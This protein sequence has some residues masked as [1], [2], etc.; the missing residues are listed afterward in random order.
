MGT[1]KGWLF[2]LHR[3]EPLLTLNLFS[4]RSGT[5]GCCWVRGI[6]RL[7]IKTCKAQVCNSFFVIL[8]EIAASRHFCSL[9]LPGIKYVWDHAGPTWVSGPRRSQWPSKNWSRLSISPMRTS[10]VLQ[11]L[12]C[13]SPWGSRWSRYPSSACQLPPDVSVHQKK[14]L[15]CYYHLCQQLC[16]S[17]HCSKLASWGA[18]MLQNLPMGL[19]PPEYIWAEFPLSGGHQEAQTKPL[20]PQPWRLVQP[21]A[22]CNRTLLLF[23]IDTRW[24][25]QNWKTWKNWIQMCGGISTTR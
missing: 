5:C 20:T 25:Y 12:L 8:A 7:F 14:G 9:R 10:L 3:R 24:R 11:T 19:A 13:A 15:G 17:K 4:L 23:Y 2:T 21:K 16:F 18:Q 6:M 22:Q 1:I